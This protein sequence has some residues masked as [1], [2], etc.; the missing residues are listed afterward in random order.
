[1]DDYTVNPD[2]LSIPRWTIAQDTCSLGCVFC[3]SIIVRV[4]IDT[5]QG[6]VL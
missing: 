5:R 2:Q 6:A 4:T 1:M 3:H